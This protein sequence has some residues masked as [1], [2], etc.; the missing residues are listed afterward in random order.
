MKELKLQEKIKSIQNKRQ[1]PQV[2]VKE[3]IYMTDKSEMLSLSDYR[4][5]NRYPTSNAEGITKKK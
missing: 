5:R 1:D 4:K 2:K 3:T